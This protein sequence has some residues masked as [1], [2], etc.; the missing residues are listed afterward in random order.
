MRYCVTKIIRTG[1]GTVR[2]DMTTQGPKNYTEYRMTDWWRD[3]RQRTLSRDNHRCRVCNGTTRLQ[4]HHRYYRGWFQER[5]E[6]M[7]TLCKRCHSLFH[8][9]MP[10]EPEG[11]HVVQTRAAMGLPSMPRQK[12][13]RRR[14]GYR[15]RYS[16]Q[17]NEVREL[18]R[19]R[20]EEARQKRILAEQQAEARRLG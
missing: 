15:H 3:L 7:T 11:K 12:A 16:D 17:N 8:G 14:K 5:D 19:L 20:V 18:T 1:I 10:E 9:I 6:D 4:A 2:A 13:K